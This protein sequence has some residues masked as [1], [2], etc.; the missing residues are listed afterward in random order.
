MNHFL[1]RA[2]QLEAQMQEDRH[3]LHKHAEA[4]EHL[5]ETVSYVMNRLREIGLEPEE[6]CPSGISAC[7][8]GAYP[9][10]TMLLRA[11]MDALPMEETNDLPFHSETNAAHNCGHD[12]HTAMLLGAAQILFEHRNDLHGNVKLMFQPAEELFIGSRKMIEAGI[13]SNPH[14]DVA[15]GMHVMLDTTVPS[16]N[17]GTG[18]MTSSCNGFK[19]TVHGSGCHGA[20]P[21]LGIDP[22]N[23]GLHIYSAFQNLIARECDPSEKVSLTFGAF[24]AGSTTN[25]VPDQAILMGT[26]RTYNKQLRKQLVKRMQEICEYTGKAFHV[27]VDYVTVSDVPSTYSDPELT[28]DLAEYASDIIPDFICDTNYKV[29]PSDDFAFISEQ[30]PTAYFMIGCQVEGCSVQHH[31]PGVL[32]DEAVL[33]YGA[34]THAACAFHWL[35]KEN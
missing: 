32:F 4:G 7:I 25:I 12:L 14:V 18:Y 8:K 16:L 5:P 11:D 3:Y 21:H 20:M 23:A 22:I 34:A 28:T 19:I 24:Q 2:K 15:M 13:L 9:G 33:P 6:I 17:Y 1:G 31:N 30:V 35:N 10:K 29:T 26:L 27:S